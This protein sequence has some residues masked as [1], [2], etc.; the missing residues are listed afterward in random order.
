MRRIPVLLWK[1]DSD[2][3]V[4]L[5]PVTS[6]SSYG[7]TEQEAIKHHIE[8]ME[9]YLEDMSKDEVDNIFDLL[10]ASAHLPKVC[11]SNIQV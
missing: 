4:S 1:E 3:Y 9:L 8:A 10:P 6:V 7:D 2:T 5:C 11:L